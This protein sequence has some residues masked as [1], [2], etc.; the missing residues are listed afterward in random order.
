MC[1]AHL[2]TILY[3]GGDLPQDVGDRIAAKV[4]LRCLWGATE[5][6]IVPQLLPPEIHPSQ[7][8]SRGL[9]H[10]IRFHPCVGAV[11]EEVTDGM[12]ELVILREQA[13]VG[14]QP[15]FTVPGIDKLSEYRTKDLFAPHPT[16]PDLWRWRARSDDIIVFLVK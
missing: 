5:T 16:M 12:H 15:C 3:I 10:Y 11:F 9:W 14:T 6:G 7:T 8:S 13:L 1:A 2:E 4:Y